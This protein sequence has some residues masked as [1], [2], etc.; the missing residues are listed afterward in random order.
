MI[1]EEIRN[2]NNEFNY[3]ILK[4]K[5]RKR[6]IQ[7]KVLRGKVI[8]L[9]PTKYNLEQ[10]ENIIKKNKC[11]ILDK[12]EKYQDNSEYLFYLGEKY[13][14][15]IIES[16]LLKK[17]S[18]EILENNFT[19]YKP[20]KQ[21][22]DLEN[23]I[24][25]WKKEKAKEI[26]LPKINLFIKNYNFNFSL[27]KNKISFK[28]QSTRWGSCSSKH[29]LN[30]NINIIEKRI[31]LIDYL[32]IHELSHT[33]FFNHSKDFWNLVKEIIPNY[34]ILKNELKYN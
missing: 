29:N 26:I 3:I 25:I 22:I 9:T 11:F 20:A 16:N 24:K 33:I 30:F 17:P 10:I 34:E 7:L 32:I 12:L 15:N 27:D 8:F 2:F 28:E 5:Q 31:E 1:L 14:I 13:K 4:S 6:T 21:E 18:Y 23:I 19:I